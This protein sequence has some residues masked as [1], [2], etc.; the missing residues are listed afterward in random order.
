MPTEAPALL[1]RP[2][3][4]RIAAANLT[5]FIR[6]VDERWRAGAHD[7]ASL[8]QWSIREPAKFWE[9]LWD[10]AGVIGDKGDPPYLLDGERMPGAAWF[11]RA[12]LNFAENLLRRR[13]DDT[14][15]VFWGEDKVRRKLTN[16]DVYDQ[17]SRLAQAL[18]AMGVTTGDRVALSAQHTGAHRPA[19]GQQH[20]RSGPPLAG[21]RRAGRALRR[22]DRTEGAAVRGRL[23]RQDHRDP[24]AHREIAASCTLEGHGIPYISAHP[25]RSFQCRLLLSS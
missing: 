20:R 16:G 22:A 23:L 15:L 6:L 1:W 21:L 14:A 3:A 24:W 2:S 9:A 10:F 5:R 19:R 25:A 11:P 18:R 7:H 13:D 4:E 12:R 17:M 8:Y